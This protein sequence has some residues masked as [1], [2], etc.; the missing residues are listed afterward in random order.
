[1]PTIVTMLLIYGAGFYYLVL[2]L[3]GVGYDKHIEA[4]PVGW[5]DLSAHITATAKAYRESSGSDV[6]IVG[7]DR[8]A[9]ASELAFYGGAH[10]PAGLQTT[11]SHLFGG[12]GLMY[13][14]WM[15]AEAQQHRNLLLVAFTPGELEDKAIEAQVERLG[16]IEDDV[17]TRGGIIIRHY[18]HRLAFDYRSADTP[19]K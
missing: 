4:I 18:Y 19:K 16:P 8:Y 9:I 3:P 6:L 12:M 5:R 10:A 14:L 11:N 2:G 1:M 7:M 13:G 17:L 15:P